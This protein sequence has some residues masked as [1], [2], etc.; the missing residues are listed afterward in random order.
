MSNVK[1]VVRGEVRDDLVGVFGNEGIKEI[2][3]A[4]K[5]YAADIERE[6]SRREPH[7]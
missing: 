7:S 2:L 3:E 5:N 6:L 1:V 4:A